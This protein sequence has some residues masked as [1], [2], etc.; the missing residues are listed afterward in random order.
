MIYIRDN[1]GDYEDY[2]LDFID[3]PDCVPKDV[4]IR[5]LSVKLV[6]YSAPCV[7][8]VASDI[9]WTRGSWATTAL[10]WIEYVLSRVDRR[11]VGGDAGGEAISLLRAEVCKAI[12]QKEGA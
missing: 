9:S 4:A 6:G 12:K 11:A 10:E 1:G 3:V 2:C 5:A 8:G 7:V